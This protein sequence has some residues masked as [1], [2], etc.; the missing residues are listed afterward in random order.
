MELIFFSL[1]LL[2]S[3]TLAQVVYPYACLTGFL[4]LAL[5][6]IVFLK[7]MVGIYLLILLYPLQS[8][9]LNVEYPQPQRINVYFDD[10]FSCVLLL[11]LILRQLS[12]RH[13]HPMYVEPSKAF[14]YKWIFFLLALFLIWS[15]F[16]VFR[17]E[18]FTVSLFGWWRFISSFV[19]IAFLLIYLDSYAKF[20]GVLIFYCFICVIYALFAIYATNYAFQVKYEL[21]QIFD[22]FISIQIALFNQSGGTLEAIVGMI[23]GIGL[24]SKHELSMLLIG[25][26]FF[27]L[28]LMKLYDSLKIR[29]V[30]L[31]FILL[32]MTIIYQVFSRISVAGMFLVVVFLCL[33]IPSWRKSTVW[34]LVILIVINLAGLFCSSLIRT[35]HMKN[36]E[37]TLQMAESVTSESEFAPSSMAL[38]KAIWERTIERI[39]GNMGMGSG[40]ASLQADIPF[41]AP[42]AHNLLLT[43]AAEYGLPGAVLIFLLLIEIARGAYKSVFI[44]PK[45]KN[46]LWL[47]QAICVGVVLCAVFEYFFDVPISHKQLWFMLGLLMASINVAEKEAT[48]DKLPSRLWVLI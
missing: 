30:L 21:F 47:L 26:I 39:S 7:P 1:L 29:C 14:S 12:E 27:S 11:V 40:P 38:R 43:L 10:I 35:T 32:F 5:F 24:A 44:E 15:I 19:I 2:A 46:N 36:M 28:F 42:N 20:I 23:T 34:V 4:C 17:S 31:T 18:Y 25:G 6:F 8:C 33:S 45:V 9:F 3:S 37:A 16:T 13:R 22:T 48:R 41:R